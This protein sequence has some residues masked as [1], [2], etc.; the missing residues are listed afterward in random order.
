MCVG[1]KAPSKLG[2]CYKTRNASFTSDL[3]GDFMIYDAP[4]NQPL[5][6]RT[7]AISP[8]DKHPEAKVRY[9]SSQSVTIWYKN[10]TKERW[11]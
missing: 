7:N 1:S 10:L 9:R 3:R 8:Q 11:R 4:V 6:V 2:L 5:E